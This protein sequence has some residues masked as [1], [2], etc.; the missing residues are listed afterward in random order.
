M[1]TLILGFYLI[2][3]TTLYGQKGPDILFAGSYYKT[4]AGAI[5]P[6]GVTAT[7][8]YH[9]RLSGTEGF[10]SD[11]LVLHGMKI[12]L[13]ENDMTASEF[14]VMVSIHQKSEVWHTARIY[15]GASGYE[16]PR[17]C[18][19]ITLEPLGQPGPALILYGHDQSGRSRLIREEFDKEHS[20]FNK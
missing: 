10:V 19:V 11:S 12:I 7:R 2:F 6:N 18:E 17:E 5:G 16:N 1:K 3:A 20:V 9:L 8:T 15:S 13:P 4:T 14:R